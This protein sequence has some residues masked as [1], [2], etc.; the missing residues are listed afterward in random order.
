MHTH[1]HRTPQ[2]NSFPSFTSKNTPRMVRES[3]RTHGNKTRISSFTDSRTTYAH[4]VIYSHRHPHSH[5]SSFAVNSTPSSKIS[6]YSNAPPPVIRVAASPR[7]PCM[8]H[9]HHLL[10]NTALTSKCLS[11]VALTLCDR[12]SG[13][14][15]R[16]RPR[17]LIGLRLPAVWSLHTCFPG[18]T[19][20]CP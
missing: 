2:P 11:C 10:P 15:P 7:A 13:H 6:T 5:L 1:L 3:H 9:P 19:Y 14:T 4:C 17:A 16:A 20:G 12:I 18:R 8:S